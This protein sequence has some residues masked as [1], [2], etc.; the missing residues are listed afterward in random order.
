MRNVKSCED[1]MTFQGRPM[2]TRAEL[3]AIEAARCKFELEAEK[4][5]KRRYYNRGHI[6][7]VVKHMPYVRKCLK[8]GKLP[9]GIPKK[10]M[11]TVF[12]LRLV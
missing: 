1:M 3:D 9:H 12:A 10:V 4:R 7:S 6:L 5:W 2:L 11:A 8:K